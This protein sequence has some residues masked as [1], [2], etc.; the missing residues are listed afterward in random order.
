MATSSKPIEAVIFA[1]QVGFGDCFLLRFV[2]PGE[3]YKHLLIDFGTTGLPANVASSHMDEI[4]RD[5]VDRCG[6]QLDAVIATHRHADH[7][8]GFATN[9]KGTASGDVIAGLK[10][11]VVIQPWTEQPDLAE[12]ATAPTGAK[13]HSLALRRMGFTAEKVVQLLDAFPK[14]VSPALKEKL[15]FVGEDNI[16][17]KSAVRNLATMAPKT[18][19]TY[20]GGPSGLTQS[21]LPGVTTHVLGPPTLRQID[22][23][24]KQRSRDPD[25][26]WHLQMA[27]LDADSQL[28][29]K[30]GAL[31]PNHPSVDGGKLPMSARWYALRLKDARG[32]QLQQIVTIL[33]DQMNNT[34]LILLFEA[35]KKK[36]LFPGDA[37]LESWQYAFSQSTSRALLKDVDLYK[38]GHHGSLNATPKSLWTDFSKRGKVGQK[39]RLKTVMSTRPGKHGNERSNTEV[40]RRTLLQALDSE[41]ELHSTHR[42]GAG[43]LYEEIHID[44][45]K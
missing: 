8:S 40:P 31:F 23:I 37:Q 12:D 7:I 19:Y 18:I 32:E 39:N 34:S 24:R 4:A 15:R 41:S 14:S 33:D 16:S 22:T 29:G 1:Y 20:H 43:V 9:A 35:G 2:Y 6:G 13:K 11:K 28:Q 10:P 26:F 30:P 36:L 3:K 38:V 27:S 5:I 17:N 21:I 45:R 44:L 25:E 42:L